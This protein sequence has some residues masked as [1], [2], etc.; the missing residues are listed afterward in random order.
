MRAE[1]VRE[2]RA[3]FEAVPKQKPFAASMEHDDNP[4]AGGTSSRQ[5]IASQGV[6]RGRAKAGTR[7][8]ARGG[9]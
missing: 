8:E 7:G 4:G 5:A 3:L 9:Q 1:S 6:A 2:D